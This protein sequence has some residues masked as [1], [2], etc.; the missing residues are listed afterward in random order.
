MTTN[1][2]ANGVTLEQLQRIEK[3]VK[4][5][6]EKGAERLTEMAMNEGRLEPWGL[7]PAQTDGNGNFSIQ[8]HSGP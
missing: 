8:L 4:I 1:W 2:G 6:P 3:D 5:H 7:S